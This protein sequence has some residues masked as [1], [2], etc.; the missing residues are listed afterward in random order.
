MYTRPWKMVFELRRNTQPGY[1]LLEFAC[2]E[3][4]RDLQHYTDDTGRPKDDRKP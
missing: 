1:Y 3:G 2:H 4:E